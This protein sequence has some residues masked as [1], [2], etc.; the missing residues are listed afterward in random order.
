MKLF[1]K[2]LLIFALLS[3]AMFSPVVRAIEDDIEELEDEP[4]DETLNEENVDSQTHAETEADEEVPEE[5][6]GS[7]FGKTNV[8]FTKPEG[9]DIPAGRLVKLLVGFQNIG[10]QEFFVRSLEASFR[11]PQ[12]SQYH[13]Q[14]FTAFEINK[15]VD[16]NMEATFEYMFSPSE[17][18]AGRQLGLTVNLRYR[19]ADGVEYTNADFNE[20]VSVVE[21]DEGLDGETFFLYIFLVVRCFGLCRTLKM[22]CLYLRILV[23]LSFSFFVR[24][25]C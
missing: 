1:T 5:E 20:T 10:N 12:A 9:A 8:L 25:S 3:L 7:P 6:T 14:N 24:L 17:T 23:L 11:Y 2:T 21:P 22:Q 15:V 4:I 16:E 13:I 18:F 19:N